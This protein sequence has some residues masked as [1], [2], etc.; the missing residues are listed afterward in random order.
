MTELVA[1][2]EQIWHEPTGL[3]TALTTVD[4][5]KIGVRYLITASA[6]AVEKAARR[7]S[8]RS[9]PGRTAS[10]VPLARHAAERRSRP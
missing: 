9:S 6:G 8:G 7:G 4:H 5:K 3:K 10:F 1:R 2:L